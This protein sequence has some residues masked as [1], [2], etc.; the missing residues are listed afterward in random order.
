M[1]YCN[2]LEN[3]RVSKPRGF[4]SHT[5][6]HEMRKVDVLFTV[7]WLNKDTLETVYIGT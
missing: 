7:M 5:L 4:E 6:L 2:S 1:D 3:C